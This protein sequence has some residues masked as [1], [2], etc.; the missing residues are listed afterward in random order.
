MYAY[1]GISSGGGN[2]GCCCSYQAEAF[3]DA[4]TRGTNVGA[5]SCCASCHD[6]HGANYNAN[7]TTA[8]NRITPDGK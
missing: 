8:I 3:S 7:L 1:G 6:N 4:Q 2:C 5:G